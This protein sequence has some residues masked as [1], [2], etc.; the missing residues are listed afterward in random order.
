MTLSS[1]MWTA[2]SGLLAHGDKMNVVGNN[3]ANVSTIGFKS[4]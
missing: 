4:Q 2:V 3:I 1:S